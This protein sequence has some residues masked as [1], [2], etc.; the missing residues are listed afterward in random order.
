MMKILLNIPYCL[1]HYV[2]N[3]LTF[4]LF[5]EKRWNQEWPG[6]LLDQMTNQGKQSASRLSLFFIVIGSIGGPKG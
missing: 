4:S 6:T 2:H 5:A 3:S 1:K